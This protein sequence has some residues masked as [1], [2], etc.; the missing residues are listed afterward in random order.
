[1]LAG[2]LVSTE[3][4]TVVLSI[5][6]RF[7]SQFQ[8]ASRSH[9]CIWILLF[10]CNI[11]CILRRTRRLDEWITLDKIENIERRALTPTKLASAPSAASLSNANN[12]TE[13]SNN[14]PSTRRR[15]TT[16]GISNSNSDEDDAGS[17]ANEGGPA[18]LLTGGNWHGSSGDPSMAAFEREHEE[19]T[20]VKN[21]ETI[22]M[23]EWQVEA[24]YYSPF[25]AAYCDLE[26]LYVCEYCLT[27]M[28]RPSTYKHH[29]ATCQCR[30]PPGKEIYRCD[31]IAVYEID[32]KEHRAYCQK[33]FLLA[34][35]FLDHKTL[36][37]ETSPFMVYVITK[38]DDH[39]AHIVGYFSKEKVR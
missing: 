22:V 21:I 23:G 3:Y 15:A 14:R 26:T 31:E 18:N 8:M 35:L 7:V 36:Y 6:I 2:T 37:F 19:A 11:E 30:N 4:S 1:M 13:A 24:W 5:A 28:K 39:G 16:A 27:Y 12:T 10:F 32:G 25:P 29:T 17:N 20:K 38:V 33:L 9:W 34:K